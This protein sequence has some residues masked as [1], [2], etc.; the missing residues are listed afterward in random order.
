MKHSIRFNGFQV[1]GA[2][3]AQV[4]KAKPIA[5]DYLQELEKRIGEVTN[6]LVPFLEAANPELLKK[7][8]S[9]LARMQQED[10]KQ[11]LQALDAKVKDECPSWARHFQALKALL[12]NYV[13]VE[14]FFKNH[15]NVTPEDLNKVTENLTRSVIQSQQLGAIRA[16]TAAQN[17]AVPNSV[18]KGKVNFLEDRTML[19]VYIAAHFPYVSED[20]ARTFIDKVLTGKSNAPWGFDQGERGRFVQELTRLNSQGATPLTQPKISGTYKT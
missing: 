1:I 15:P 6:R 3:A 11:Q 5:H 14:N 4:I 12:K 13:E 7:P 9:E 17:G 8:I 20:D 2:M 10:I 19:R 18:A 16:A